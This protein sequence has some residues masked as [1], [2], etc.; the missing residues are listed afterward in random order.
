MGAEA[1]ETN[2][3]DDPLTLGLATVFIGIP[4]AILF[5]D[6]IGIKSQSTKHDERFDVMSVCEADTKI[7]RGQ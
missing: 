6:K 1:D 2:V 3:E 7:P 5:H 4:D